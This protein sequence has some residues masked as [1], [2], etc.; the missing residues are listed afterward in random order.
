LKFS[1]NGEVSLD[2]EAAIQ[3]IM[4]YAEENKI[5]FEEAYTEYIKKLEV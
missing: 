3:E 2:E 5:E 1:E 4:K